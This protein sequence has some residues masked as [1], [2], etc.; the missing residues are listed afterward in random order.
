VDHGAR[1]GRAD[2]GA[3]RSS[4]RRLDSQI[5]YR[6]CQSDDDCNPTLTCNGG[7]DA[8]GGSP[9]CHK[10]MCYCVAR[11]MPLLKFYL[12]FSLHCHFVEGAQL[13]DGDKRIVR[14]IA[15][16]NNSYSLLITSIVS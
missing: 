4:T 16:L 8:A 14:R 11:R 7:K 6:A 13:L 15:I 3:N 9:S 12:G 1:H 10:E 2:R 5:K